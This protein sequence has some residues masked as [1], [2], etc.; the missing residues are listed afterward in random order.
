MI[1]GM[2]S[3][4]YMLTLFIFIYIYCF[5]SVHVPQEKHLL[6][7]PDEGEA[8][9]LFYG[10][11]DGGKEVSAKLNGSLE[12]EERL[13]WWEEQKK[14]KIVDEKDEDHDHSSHEA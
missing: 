6:P 11:G 4:L 8:H 14:F 2:H 13:K 9:S 5:Y 10:S 1:V 7:C 3:S 12:G